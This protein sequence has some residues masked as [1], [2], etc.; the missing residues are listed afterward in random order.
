MTEG[1]TTVVSETMSVDQLL[2]LA[3]F[4]CEEV[5]MYVKESMYVDEFICVEELLNVDEL[6]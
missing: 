3:E 5:C 1:F 6:M 2:Y 4:T